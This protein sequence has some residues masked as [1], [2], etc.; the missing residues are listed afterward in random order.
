MKISLSQEFE[1]ADG[2]PAILGGQKV[3]LKDILIGSLLDG[4][5]PDD[6]KV[7]RYSLYRDVKKSRVG[8]IEISVEEA[9]FLKKVVLAT[10]SVLVTGQAHE[11]LETPYI[12]PKG[13][14][15]DVD[16]DKFPS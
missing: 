13:K 10:Q 1:N 5:S 14:K 15:V 4:R 7:R 2:T 16:T 9:A 11:M 8:F 12:V 3:T 6:E